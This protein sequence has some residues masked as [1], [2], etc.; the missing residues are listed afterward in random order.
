MNLT[1]NNLL[2]VCIVKYNYKNCRLSICNLRLRIANIFMQGH[3]RNYNNCLYSREHYL[4]QSIPLQYLTLLLNT[5]KNEK[6]TC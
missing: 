4:P 3:I 1:P 2:N 6:L 5:T